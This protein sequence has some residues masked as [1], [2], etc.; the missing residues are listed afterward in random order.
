LTDFRR[1]DD[2]FWQ[3]RRVFPF[4][5][6]C[7]C[8]LEPQIKCVADPLRHQQDPFPRKHLLHRFLRCLIGQD[9][10]TQPVEM[11]PHLCIQ[12]RRVDKE[13]RAVGQYCQISE[14]NRVIGD[15]PPAQ[16]EQ[17]CNVVQGRD[18]VRVRAGSNLLPQPC[19]LFFRRLSGVPLGQHPDWRIGQRRTVFPKFP[20]EVAVEEPRLPAERIEQFKC[21]PRGEGPPVPGEQAVRRHPLFQVSRDRRAIRMAGVEQ[22]DP[23]PLQLLFCL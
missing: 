2:G 13:Q 19:E 20:C 14:R 7:L 6:L 22:G 1:I 9:F 17:P 23:A 3:N 12:L 8:R 11:R 16:I 18:Q 4:D 5:D 15:V 10:N 21:L